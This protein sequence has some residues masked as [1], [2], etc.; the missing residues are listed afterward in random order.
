MVDQISSLD[1]NDKNAHNPLH[2]EQVK[3]DNSWRYSANRYLQTPCT[4][5]WNLKGG[6]L[7]SQ[8]RSSFDAAEN[9]LVS[10]SQSGENKPNL[11]NC[12]AF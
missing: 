8:M 11:E 2:G 10:L 1:H 7:L 4:R 6:V 12:L 5:I 3:L 9:V